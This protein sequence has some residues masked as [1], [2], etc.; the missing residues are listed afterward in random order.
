VVQPIG[1]VG[2]TYVV[3]GLGNQLA[4][5]PETGRSDGLTAVVTVTRGMDGKYHASGIEAVPTYIERGTFRVLPI[6]RTLADPATPP[7]LRADLEASYHRT[8]EVLATSPTVG[9][10][11]TPLP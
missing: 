1:Q 9:V 11:L 4:N 5:Q 7:G 8:E 6:S 10:T 2:G 3:W